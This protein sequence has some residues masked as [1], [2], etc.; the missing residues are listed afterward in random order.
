MTKNL[1]KLQLK[2][3]V[4]IFLSQ[5]AI[6]LS[7]GLHNGRLSYRRSHQPQKRTSS[8]LKHEISGSAFPMLILIRTQPTEISA[9]PDP[10]H[11]K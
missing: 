6:Y 3:C 2:K 4:L 7:L 10:K 5:T 1:K 9:D 8:T 11:R